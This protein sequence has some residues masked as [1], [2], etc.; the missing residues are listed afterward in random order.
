MTPPKGQSS[1]FD[2]GAVQAVTEQDTSD[3]KCGFCSSTTL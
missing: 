1:L 3:T 2:S